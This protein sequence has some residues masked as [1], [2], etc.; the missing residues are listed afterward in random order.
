VGD[1]STGKTLLAIEA[2]ANFA[3]KFPEGK[4]WY[5]EIEA[6]FDRDYAAKL[7]LPVDNVSFTPFNRNLEMLETV[8]QLEADLMKAVEAN[9]ARKPALYIV[10]SLDALSDKSEMERDIEK[11]DF[12][13]KKAKQMSTIFRKLNKTVCRANITVI[14]ISQ[15]RDK[16]GVAFGKKWTRSG[17]RSLDFYA[18]IILYLAEL[19]KMVKSSGNVKRPIGV[20]IRAKTEKNKIGLPFRECDFPIVFR[21]G[22]DDEMAMIDFLKSV[23]RFDLMGDEWN[24]TRWVRMKS[25]I[26]ADPDVRKQQSRALRRATKRAWREIEESFEPTG[27][28]Y[29]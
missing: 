29:G 2:C 4:I 22:I 13:A 6:A 7:G 28:K 1:R 27:S 17:G 5:R 8:E 3:R 12:G 19:G 26:I 20:N 23:D 14:I 15:I 24:R 11:G 10:D 25:K 18:S 16:I 21:W 9:K